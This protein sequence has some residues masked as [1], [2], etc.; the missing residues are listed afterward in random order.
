MKSM[1]RMLTLTS[2]LTLS[3]CAT[4]SGCLD[5]EKTLISKFGN[6][7]FLPLITQANRTRYS[8]KLGS[9]KLIEKALNLPDLTAYARSYGYRE[10]GQTYT[11]IKQE[12]NAFISFDKAIAE[13]G[14]TGEEAKYFPKFVETLREYA[15][16]RKNETNKDRDA[17]PLVRIPPFFPSTATRSG[18]CQMKFDVD[19]IGRPQ[20]IEALYCTQKAFIE[21]ASSSLAKWTYNPKISNGKAVLRKDVMSKISFRLTDTCGNLI[22]E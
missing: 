9:I 18:H 17:Q 1:F 10:L 22:P 11:A 12:G 13:N 4:S 5:I 21:P 3:S 2:A 19:E 15:T 7:D 20:N 8:D 14:F 16:N 6:A